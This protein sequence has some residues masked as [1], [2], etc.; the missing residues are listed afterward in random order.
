MGIECYD[1]PQSRR[2][3]C[4]VVRVRY[5]DLADCTAFAGDEWQFSIGG[6][7]SFGVVFLSFCRSR[8]LIV[9]VQ[10]FLACYIFYRFV[11][12]SSFVL[13]RGYAI[14]SSLLISIGGVGIFGVVF[15]FLSFSPSDRFR[16]VVL[17]LLFYRL[18]DRSSFVLDRGYA[19]NSSLLFSIGGVGCFG[20]VLSFLS[21][22]LSDSSRSFV[23]SLL[24]SVFRLNP[25]FC[26]NP[27]SGEFIMG[28]HSEN[29][30]SYSENP[31][32]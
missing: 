16:S 11:D 30:F 14:I 22:S 27:A 4:F 6:V 1:E 20:V 18:D 17:S 10:S 9:F 19:I 12:R 24:F 31:F 25:I 13:D 29:G 5:D 28:C 3:L 15:V 26:V 32:G 2:R 8:F 23:L 21:F 7:G